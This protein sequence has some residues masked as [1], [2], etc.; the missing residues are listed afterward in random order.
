MIRP[1][2][3]PS[4]MPQATTPSVAESTFSGYRLVLA[5]VIWLA[6][7]IPS[8]ALFVA[9]LPIYAVLI[10]GPC[11]G[12]VTCNIAG[13]LTVSGMASL[14]GLGLSPGVYAALMT[15]FFAMI[16]VIWAGIGLLI[17]WRRSDQ[18]F[19]LLTGFFLVMFCTTYPGFPISALALKAPAL[20][21]PIMVMGALGL[22][23]LVLFFALFPNGRLVPLWIAP[24][25][26]FA[27]LSAVSAVMPLAWRTSGGSVPGWLSGSLTTIAFVVIIGAQV[28]RFARV[29]APY[30]RQQTKWV[31]SG[32]AAVLSE[33]FLLAPLIAYFYPPVNTQPNTPVSTFISLVTYPLVMLLL[34]ITIGVAILRSRLYDIDIIIKR[35]LVYG[36]LTLA[37]GVVYFGLIF[38]LETLV[39]LLTG[40]NGQSQAII[41]ISTLTIAAL[42]QPLRGRVQRTIDRRFYR[43]SYNAARM[44]AEFGATLRS[45]VD[46]QQLNQHLMATVREAMHPVS[47]SLWLR[48]LPG[49]SGRGAQSA[50]DNAV[51]SPVVSD[52]E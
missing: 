47:V 44:V 13:T 9:S 11:D 8:L 4:D 23:S 40:H 5:R 45:E 24:A 3:D 27:M 38:G 7:V 19:A 25:L 34:P 28:Y 37:L 17:F 21:G 42:F 51:Q 49:S 43:R 46:L 31:V 32:I 33:I 6:L 1:G 16:V 36:S 10:Q 26:M 39:G 22:A 20:N 41:V 52:P 29:S 50:T 18:W 14:A 12:P 35:T 30:E 2:T 15:T 48:P